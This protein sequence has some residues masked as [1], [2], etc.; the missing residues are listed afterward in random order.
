L[1]LVSGGAEDGQIALGTISAAL[2]DT[3]GSETLTMTI[4][5]IPVGAVLTDGTNT[6]TAT[7]GNTSVNVTS[8]ALTNISVTPVPNFSGTFNLTVTATSTETS[9][10]SASS[11]TTLPITVYAVADTPS[12]AVQN[13]LVSVAAGSSATS[14]INVP[15]M[16]SLKDTDGSETLTVVVSGFDTTLG[17]NASLF[18]AGTRTGSGTSA[19]WTFTAA[20]LVDLHMT[21][22]AGYN[23]T[24]LVLT[25][26]ATS[27]ESSNGATSTTASTITLYADDTTNTFTTGTSAANTINDSNTGHYISALGGNDTVNASGG[28]DKVLGGDGNDTING[29]TG[30]DALFGEAG[31]DI[32]IGGTGTDYISG[33]AGNDTLTGSATA[34]STS[35]TTVDVF[36]WTLVDAGSVGTPAVDTITDFVTN[37]SGTGDVIDLRDLLSGDVRGEGN[38]VGNLL[39]YIDIDTTVS[40]QT[41]IHISSSGG[42]SGGVYNSAV[43]DQTIV[44]SNQ[45]LATTLGTSSETQI[46]ETLLQRGNLIVD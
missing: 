11:S 8:W 17:N 14:V 10:G 44:I 7:T 35:D 1:I 30:N 20:D 37:T 6:F 32:I 5:N 39:S 24:G 9:G 29:G 36:A 28:N 27:T 34:G 23:N 41:T 46:I 38:T 2:N 19:T 15:I 21:L 22:P 42:F 13:T 25:V 40:G 18:S 33:G 3:D 16:A 4:S 26:S 45:N 12:L 43:E 31:N